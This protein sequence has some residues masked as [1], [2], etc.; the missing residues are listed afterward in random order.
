MV[1]ILWK[2]WILVTKEDFINWFK[3]HFANYKVEIISWIPQ[4]IANVFNIKIF[5]N[6]DFYLMLYGDTD[7]ACL[8]KISFT[9]S[10]ISTLTQEQLYLAQLFLHRN[11]MFV[12]NEIHI[13]RKICDL[14]NNQIEEFITIL[15]WCDNYLHRED[16]TGDSSIEDYL[17]ENKAD[18][19][20]EN[21]FMELHIY[22]DLKKPT[23][24]IDYFYFV[25]PFV[26]T[27]VFAKSL[28]KD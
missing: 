2:D 8:A 19:Y 28:R 24:T 1:L 27:I 4:T 18:Y 16:F 13:L 3:T 21:N 10:W 17:I 7:E 9:L 11:Y 26:E 23:V 22:I 20:I 6:K 5:L 12:S 14:T 25:K 15:E